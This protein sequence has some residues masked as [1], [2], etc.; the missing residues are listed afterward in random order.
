MKFKDIVVESKIFDG[1][2]VTLTYIGEGT[3]GTYNPKDMHDVPVLRFDVSYHGEQIE[4]GSYCTN[5]YA[6]AKR[7][8]L[9]HAAETILIKAEKYHNQPEFKKIME[10][11]SHITVSTMGEY[12]D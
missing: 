2:S 1:L 12:R 3:N 7:E 10:E 6:R 4:D 5:L 8:Q 11:L 9:T